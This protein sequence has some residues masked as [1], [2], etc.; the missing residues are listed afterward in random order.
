MTPEE[1]KQMRIEMGWTQEIMAK[2][3]FVSSRTIK[4][5]ESGERKISRPIQQ[6]LYIEQERHCD[7][8]FD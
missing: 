5:Y 4:H 6:L 7:K 3:L 2:K 8:Q 1:F